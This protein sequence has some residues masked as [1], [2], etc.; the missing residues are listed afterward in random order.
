MSPMSNEGMRFSN[1][2]VLLESHR[3]R[4][5]TCKFGNSAEPLPMLSPA[6]SLRASALF[7]TS[8]L[9]SVEIGKV[10]KTEAAKPI[11]GSWI[12]LPFV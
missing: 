10:V 3:G 4:A 6:R 1:R 7:P 2:A 11:E 5:I 12:R 8:F 9:S